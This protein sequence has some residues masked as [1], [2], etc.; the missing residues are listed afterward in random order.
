MPTSMIKKCTL[1]LPYPRARAGVLMSG[2]YGILRITNTNSTL[3]TLLFFH[4]S[5]LSETLRPKVLQERKKG[6]MEG[7]GMRM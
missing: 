7:L 6:T 5:L 4:F 1:Y 2:I 3:V